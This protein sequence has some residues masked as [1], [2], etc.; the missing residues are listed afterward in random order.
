MTRER[1]LLYWVYKEIRRRCGPNAKDGDRQR[2]YE[3]GIRLCDRWLGPDGFQ[4]FLDDM[5]PRPTP[6]HEIDRVDND[7]D[8]E[9]GNCRWVTQREQDANR[10]PNP[11]AIA[12]EIC[13]EV[14]KAL[15][16]GATYASQA[17]RFG[18]HHETPKAIYTRH[19]QRRQHV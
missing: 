11:N 4:N 14:V 5:G 1:Q 9:P 3:R 13:D 10:R 16:S 8:Y 2:Y 15:D 19:Q 12:P 7:G 17:R 6:H 18:L